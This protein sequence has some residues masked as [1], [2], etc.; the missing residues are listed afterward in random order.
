MDGLKD[1]IICSAIGASSGLAGLSSASG[2]ASGACSSCFGCAGAG[3]C[4]LLLL[5][6]KKL[7]AKA[8][9]G[10]RQFNNCCDNA[11]KLFVKPS[12]MRL[13][14]SKKGVKTWNG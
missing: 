14:N 13:N 11:L 10:D 3:I 9:G 1:K 2:C 6:L 4:I 12:T 7:S 8:G 5:A